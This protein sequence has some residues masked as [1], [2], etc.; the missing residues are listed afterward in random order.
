VR[1]KL[2]A[3]VELAVATEL[4]NSGERFPELKDVTVPTLTLYC[5]MLSVFVLWV[6]VDAPLEP[7]VVKV[8]GRLVMLAA[9]MVGAATN[10]TVHVPVVLMVHVPETPI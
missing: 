10:P 2:K 7:T 9:E 8:I 5:G 3:G 6:Y 4:V 1:L